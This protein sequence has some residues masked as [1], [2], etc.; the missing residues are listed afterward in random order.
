MPPT[1]TPGQKP[2]LKLASR[3]VFFGGILFGI[4]QFG[5]SQLEGPNKSLHLDPNLISVLV[6]V[7]LG[8]VVLGAIIFVVGRMRRL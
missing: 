3:L 4:E 7:P 2:Y 6:L 1:P 5:L 8:M